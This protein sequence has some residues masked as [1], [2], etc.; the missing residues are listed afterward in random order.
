MLSYFFSPTCALLL[1]P[2]SL[3]EPSK[4]VLT[5][6]NLTEWNNM[7]SMNYK[8]R[9]FLCL[10]SLIIYTPILFRMQ[11]AYDYNGRRLGQK[12]AE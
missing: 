12:L 2:F 9:I 11:S 10:L 6:C 5:G 3:F 1:C 8:T 4:V 7:N